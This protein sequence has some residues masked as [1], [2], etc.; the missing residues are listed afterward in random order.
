MMNHHLRNS[1][2]VL[3]VISRSLELE[4]QDKVFYSGK[5]NLLNQPEFRDLDK[6]R[7]ILDIL[8][9]DHIMNQVVRGKENGL[10]IKIG[11]E[12]KHEAFDNCSMIT[13]SYTVAGKHMGT[14]GI[15]GPTRMEY[16]RVIGV[17]DTISE[18]LTYFLNKLY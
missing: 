1:N 5:M 16:R 10:Q 14:I 4:K 2:Q 12:N 11:H 9:Q 17:V 13:A 15:I 7:V 6:V 8:E 18:N 3:S